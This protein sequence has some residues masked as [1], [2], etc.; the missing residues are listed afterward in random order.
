M[1]EDVGNNHNYFY[2]VIHGGV[3]PQGYIVPEGYDFWSTNYPP[4]VPRRRLAKAGN[5]A[6]SVV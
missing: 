2:I 6:R 3:H 1:I 4:L 5:A